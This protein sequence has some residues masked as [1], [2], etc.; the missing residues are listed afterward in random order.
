MFSAGQFCKKTHVRIS[1]V[2]NYSKGINTVSRNF[3]CSCY[4]FL[5]EQIDTILM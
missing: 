3:C 4:S 2:G 1:Y 5:L